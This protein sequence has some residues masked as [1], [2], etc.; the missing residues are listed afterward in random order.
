MKKKG[1]QGIGVLLPLGLTFVVVAVAIG[2]G[3]QVVSTVQSTQTENSTS[4]NT[5]AYGLTS[6]KTIGQ[7]LPTIALVAVAG[8]IIAILITFMVMRGRE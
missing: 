3:A 7:W 6:L 4:W 5:S 2:I 8:I 1:Q